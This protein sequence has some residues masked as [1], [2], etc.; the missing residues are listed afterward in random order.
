[1]TFEE[2]IS[3]SKIL[4]IAQ[5]KELIGIILRDVTYSTVFCKNQT[6]SGLYRARQ[7]SQIDGE[8]DEYL[9]INEK[10]YWNPPPDSI[11]S[12]GRC[13]DIGESLF[14]CSNEFETAILEIRPEVGRFVSVAKF[15]PIKNDTKL[16]SFR[17]KPNCIQHLKKIKGFNSCIKNIDLSKRDQIFLDTDN[18][19]DDLFTEIVDIKD[20]YKYKVTNAITQCMLTKIVNENQEEFSMNGM[21]YP[22]IINNKKSVNILLKPIYVINNYLIKTIQTFE[23]L[24]VSNN[25]VTIGLVRNGRTKGNKKHPSQQLDLEWFG[26]QNGEKYTIEF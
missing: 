20:S 18:L 6:F 26:I 23:V 8:S 21:I 7:H 22:S 19:L 24:E 1:M 14:Y 12:I 4:T 11:K 9:F 25:T 17:I 13:N 16:P 5:L 15:L 2:I 3:K 10:E